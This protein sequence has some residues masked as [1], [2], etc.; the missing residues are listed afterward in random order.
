M[1]ILGALFLSHRCSLQGQNHTLT[2]IE[3]N[4]EESH[5]DLGIGTATETPS[6]DLKAQWTDLLR[7][8]DLQIS[9]LTSQLAAFQKKTSTHVDSITHAKF[10][11]NQTVKGTT[12]VTVT[13]GTVPDVAVVPNPGVALPTPNQTIRYEWQDGH[14]RFHLIDTN[15]LVP[16]NATFTSQQQFNLTGV[17]LKQNGGD[18]KAQS[19]LLEEVDSTG[20]VVGKA[21]LANA[22]FNY[23]PET[24]A[25]TS[26]FEPHALLGIGSTFS[27]TNP[28]NANLGA[29]I[30]QWK[31]VSLG[32][33]IYS[34]LK[35][36][37]NSG[38]NALVLYRPA[39]HGTLVNLALAGGIAVTAELTV[40]P[41]LGLEL[42]AW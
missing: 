30:V 15:I 29:S 10:Q 16:G 42:I 5:T 9:A 14:K 20:I 23:A 34:D 26:W 1:V 6:D 35:H 7:S 19:L 36:S 37:D 40:R 3:A 13:G 38:V 39:I 22:T 27:T 33:T 17:I 18:L 25:K 32:A 12:V 8:K 2:P 21:T 24:P 41:Y 11:E 28:I 31:S 4:L